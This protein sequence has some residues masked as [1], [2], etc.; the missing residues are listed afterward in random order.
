MREPAVLGANTSAEHTAGRD[1]LSKIL[2]GALRS[3]APKSVKAK[4]LSEHWHG[5]GERDTSGERVEAVRDLVQDVIDAGDENALAHLRAYPWSTDLE[6]AAKQLGD[7]FQGLGDDGTLDRYPLFVTPPSELMLPKGVDLDAVTSTLDDISRNGA[8]S[9]IRLNA[10][11]A[12]A[13]HWQLLYQGAAGRQTFLRRL[14]E[15]GVPSQLLDDLAADGTFCA[16]LAAD[17]LSAE[18][19]AMIELMRRATPRGG[20][21]RPPAGKGKAKAGGLATTGAADGAEGQRRALLTLLSV[22]QSNVLL[23]MAAARDRCQKVREATAE[24]APAP[25]EVAR[26][27]SDVSAADG[28]EAQQQAAVEK[29]VLDISLACEDVSPAAHVASQAW[30]RAVLEEACAFFRAA[31]ALAH[32]EPSGGGGGCAAADPFTEPFVTLLLLPLLTSPASGDA[33]AL[34]DDGLQHRIG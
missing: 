28:G 5:G 14:M 27:A 31:A 3:L 21:R 2:G 23:A 30:V 7:D 26:G 33:A 17:T 10:L 1:L 24:T 32:G 34:A 13:P 11:Y 9:P 16:S 29:I 18:P 25:P 12:F 20:E 22:V 6:A 19:T 4:S 8:T 15:P